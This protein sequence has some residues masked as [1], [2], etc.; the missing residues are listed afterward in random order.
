VWY[1]GELPFTYF[2]GYKVKVALCWGLSVFYFRV[3]SCKNKFLI[4]N[5]QRFMNYAAVVSV[6]SFSAKTFISIFYNKH[7]F[8][9]C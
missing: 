6:G 7:N 3:F 2:Y 1:S 4:T 9:M 8:P 5:L